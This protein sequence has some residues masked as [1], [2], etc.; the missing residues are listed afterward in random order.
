MCDMC[1]IWETKKGNHVPVASLGCAVQG[2]P[3]LSSETVSHNTKGRGSPA[4]EHLP[5]NLGP[6]LAGSTDHN[7]GKC[8]FIICLFKKFPCCIEFLQS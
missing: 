5:G 7:R 2:Q 6:W 3:E 1:D 4:I 8:V